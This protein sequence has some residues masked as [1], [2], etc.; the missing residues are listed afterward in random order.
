MR[1]VEPVDGSN[2]R[3]IKAFALL[4]VISSG[5][6]FFASLLNAP[7]HMRLLSGQEQLLQVLPL[8]TI[9]DLNGS[10]GLLVPT[11]D[12][13]ALRPKVLGRVDLE[14]RFLDVIPLRQMVVDVVP[15]LYV[16]PGGQA[17]GVLLSTQGL[18]VSRTVPVID[19]N[20][21]ELH[22]AR[23]AG[24]LPGDIIEAIAGQPV[25]SV[26]HA[27]ALI[28]TMG[29]LQRDIAFTV[30]RGANRFTVNLQPVLVR[31]SPGSGDGGPK[32][33]LGMILEEPTAGVWQ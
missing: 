4:I 16:R 24:I 17:I 3:I 28:D 21:V 33:M 2:Q 11:D 22:P 31:P 6:L 25:R 9:R 19:V 15:Q 10:H 30:K 7:V 29:R 20:G 18:I 27:A 8:F 12:G 13:V 5:L 26:Q 32:Y 14:L 23:D 1:S